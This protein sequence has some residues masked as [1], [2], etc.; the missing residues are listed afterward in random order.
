LTA[1][2]WDARSGQELRTQDEIAR[3]LWATRRDPPWHAE[4]VKALGQDPPPYAL[5]LHRA[6]AAGLHPA[7]VAELRYAFALAASGHHADAA[8]AL[9]RAACAAPEDDAYPPAPPDK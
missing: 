4:Q 8:G 5:A 9:L 2:L 1:R 3:R 6:L 7:A